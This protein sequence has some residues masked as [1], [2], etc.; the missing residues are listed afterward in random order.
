MVAVFLSPQALLGD[1]SRPLL[2]DSSTVSCPGL[3]ERERACD[4]LLDGAGAV[5]RRAVTFKCC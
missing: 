1:L 4:P 3:G 5:R 2:I